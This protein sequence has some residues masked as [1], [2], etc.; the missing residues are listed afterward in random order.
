MRIV[1]HDE[2]VL[3]IDGATLWIAL[4]CAAVGLPLL[5][6]GRLPS[7]HLL[8][9]AG[10]FFFLCAL[11][12]ARTTRFSFDAR[13]QTV[14]WRVQRLLVSRT[15]AMS[16]DGISDI[17]AEASGG[18]GRATYRLALISAGGSVPMAFGFTSDL[19]HLHEVRATILSYVRP[20]A[21]A[22][23]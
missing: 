6:E 18:G 7:H 1:R 14:R 4:L 23:G 22:E 8:L 15:G 11:I 9:T 12:S 3:V 5:Y 16:F 20:G 2:R 19:G 13:S 17:A 21:G 10:G